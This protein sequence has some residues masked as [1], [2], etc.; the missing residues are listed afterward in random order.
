MTHIFLSRLLPIALVSAVATHATA[1]TIYVYEDGDNGQKFL[2]NVQQNASGTKKFT[3]I[4]VTYYP[5]TKLHSN[6]NIPSTYNPTTAA[7]PSRSANRNAYDHLIR[8]AAARHG[9]DPALVKAIIHTES[10]FNPNARSPVGAMGLMQLMPGTA[11]DMGVSN[12]WDPVQNIEGGVKYI[13]WLQRQ[14]RNRDHVVAAYNAGLGNVRKH[15]GI[16]PFRETQNYVRSV[17]SR[18]ASLYRHD[19]GIIG[20]GTHLAMN[21]NFTTPAPTT[22][23]VP[24]SSGVQN[25][26]ITYTTPNN[27]YATPQ[28]PSVGSGSGRIYI[29]K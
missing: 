12:A 29:H 25:V 26:S 21:Q 27:N 19:T 9:V 5:D 2:T 6:G 8:A 10:A 22:L 16:P 3:Q 24:S 13:A 7:T 11:R 1:N 23:Q 28:N 15:G 17:N 20:G 4:S 18:Y 14:F